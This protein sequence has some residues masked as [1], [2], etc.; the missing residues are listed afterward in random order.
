MT[1]NESGGT[2]VTE[3]AE[4]KNTDTC[5]VV[6]N[7]EPT[8]SVSVAIANLSEILFSV[9]S[10]ATVTPAADLHHHHWANRAN[11]TV[12]LRGVDDGVA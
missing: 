1:I 9:P 10:T 3:A 6:L 12:R 8:A 5:T 7:T 4:V 2:L 11:G